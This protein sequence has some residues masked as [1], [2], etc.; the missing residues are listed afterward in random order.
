MTDG[1]RGFYKVSGLPPP[2]TSASVIVMSAGSTGSK[3][4]RAPRVLHF[5]GV[6]DPFQSWTVKRLIIGRG[7]RTRPR[8]AGVLVHLV[9][10]PPV[11]EAY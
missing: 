3:R 5:I 6:A 1:R 11:Q 4:M 7:R 8:A 10:R 9:G 2:V